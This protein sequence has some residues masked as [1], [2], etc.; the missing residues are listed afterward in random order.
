[1]VQ[2]ARPDMATGDA[3]NLGHDSDG[4]NQ[5]GSLKRIGCNPFGCNPT[6]LDKLG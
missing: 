6:R 4:K 2:F 1:M 5:V 3:S